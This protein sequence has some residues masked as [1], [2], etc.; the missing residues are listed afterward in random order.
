MQQPHLGYFAQRG[1][2]RAGLLRTHFDHDVRAYRAGPMFRRQTNA[3]AG[4][5]ALLLQPLDS[6]LNAGAR[7]SYQPGQHRGRGT[8]VLA[9]RRQ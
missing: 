9:Q 7:A 6:T 8:A 4:D 3:V 5:D 2:H 1:G